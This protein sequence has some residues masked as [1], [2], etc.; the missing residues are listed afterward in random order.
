MRALSVWLAA[1]LFAA[2]L[3]A[4]AAVSRYK[5]TRAGKLV[6][7]ASYTHVAIDTLDDEVKR[8]KKDADDEAQFREDIRAVSE[9]IVDG[10]AQ[11]L[12]DSGA[13]ETVSREVSDATGTLL[14]DGK[15]TVFK[16]ANVATR[17]LGLG[18]G[19]KL[20]GVVVVKDAASGE[21]LGEI[22][23]DFSSSGIPGFTNLVQTVDAF[24]QGIVV[25][26]SDEILIAKGAKFREETGRSAR[27][28]EKYRRD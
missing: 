22:E 2:S 26:V 11:R 3:D 9:R 23:L 25:R 5:P 8:R 28:R 24:I 27:L 12:R 4:S 6:E 10:V 13:F 20:E 21:V 17:Y 7:L 18:A 15:L 16:R 19:S 14:V 1:A